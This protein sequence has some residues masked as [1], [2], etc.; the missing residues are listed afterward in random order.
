MSNRLKFFRSQMAA[1]E[2]T[3][4]PQRAIENGYYV[5]EP[6]KSASS[7]ITRVGLRPS[8]TH[9]LIGGIGSGKTTQLHIAR[10]QFNE[11]EDVSA[12]YVDVSTY[13]NI[14]EIVPG[15]LTA[16][17]GLVLSELTKSAQ[18]IDIEDYQDLITK[19]AYGYSETVTRSPISDLLATTTTTTKRQ[20]GV[21]SVPNEAIKIQKAIKGLNKAASSDF[22]DIVLFFDGLDRL[23]DVQVFSQIV[24]TDVQHIS[25]AGI[26]VVLVGPLLAAYSQYRDIIEPA[27][28]YT[29]YQSCF[30][31]ENDPE[32]Y[33]FFN[34]VLSIRSRENFLEK[35]AVGSLINY[36]GGVLRDLIN[37][38]QFSIEEA[39]I[40]DEDRLQPKHVEAA[41]NSLGRAKMLSISDQDLNVLKKVSET[42]NFIPRTD[43]EIR[44]LV[45][46]R[47]LEYQYPKRRFAVHPT[48]LLLMQEL[49][50]QM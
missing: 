28:N 5:P 24:T 22:G 10:N 38:A 11:I 27:V 35:S 23:D 33:T 15:V 45:T 47:I 39:Y 46:G 12:H 37:L 42:G 31:L 49:C 19:Y 18:D 7:L 8:A 50:H 34:K 14:S 20:K 43:A 44:L 26:G 3:A 30:D 29:T 17:S 48:I 25:A 1:F 6:R 16:I 40:S 13:T 9:L 32:A 36:S 41:A 4:D 2:G 21:L